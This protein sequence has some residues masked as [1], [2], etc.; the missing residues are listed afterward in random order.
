[1]KPLFDT[2]VSLFVLI[3]LSPLLSVFS[4]LIWLQDFSSPFYVAPRVGKNG[5][6]FKMVKLRSM[7][8]NSDQSGVTST[9]A[10]D[11]RI[12]WIGHIIRRYK[13]DEFSQFWNVLCGHMS[14]VGPR[15]NVPQGVELYTGVENNLLSVKPGI[16]D[17]ASIVFSDEADIL[18]GSADPDQ[19]YD[20]IIRPWK[21][22]LGLFY[23]EKRSFL[24]DIK[25]ICLTA[26]AIVSRP[27]ALKGVQTILEHL[28]ADPQLVEVSGRKQ[29][30][31]PGRPPGSGWE[32]D[33]GSAAK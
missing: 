7:T 25:I 12:T 22:R 6:I 18:D 8:I 20:Q 31:K 32:T 13:L 23:I 1:M 27:L 5:K 17:F 11:K 30:L 21:S 10:D 15:P 19:K 33:M 26:V 14:L 29:P 16:T 28:N 9:A 3:L 2:M 24:L 4:V